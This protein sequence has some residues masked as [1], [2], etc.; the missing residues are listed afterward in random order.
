[1]KRSFYF[2]LKKE[3]G[4]NL[5]CRYPLKRISPVKIGGPADFIVSVDGTSQ[6]SGLFALC[7]RYKVRVH[8]FGGGWNTLFSD[9]GFRGVI[10]R[11]GK[12]MSGIKKIREKG[13]SVFIETGSGARLPALLNYCVKKGFSGLEFLAGIPGTAGGALFGNAGTAKEGI[14]KTVLEAE[15]VLSS[16]RIVGKKARELGFRYR[17]SRINFFVTSAVFRLKKK[18]RGEVLRRI[19]FY[20]KKRAGQPKGLSLGSVFKNP[21]GL[22]AGKLIEDCGYK[23]FAFGGCGVSE[24]HANFIMNRGRGTSAGYRKII[25]KIKKSV[26]KKTGITLEEEIVIC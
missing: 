9:R 7:R 16:G 20:L 8:F 23:G 4:N 1:M 2:L 18:S 19:A 15:G 21:E 3:F 22:Y 14:G 10:V 26:R 13:S 11:P 6:V 17:S 12:G 24:R 25:E 5:L